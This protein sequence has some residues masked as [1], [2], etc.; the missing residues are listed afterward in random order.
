MR[1]LEL[2]S[3]AGGLAIGASR[4]GF[5]H[6]GLLELDRH[7]CETVNRN[8]RKGCE[9]VTG[10]PLTEST[11]VRGV[12]F[13]KYLDQVDLIAAGPPCQPFSM[14][15]K[16]AAHLDPRDMF[17]ETIR[18][19][20]ESRPK[21]V[22]VENVKG[23]G[24]ERYATY[25]EYILLQLT[26]PSFAPRDNE[27]MVSH[28]SRLERHNSSGGELEYRVNFQ[29]LNAADYGVPQQRQRVFIVA[30]RND[31]KADWSFQKDLP[32]TH[33]RER[34]LYNQWVT[35]SYWERHGIAPKVERPNRYTRLVERLSNRSVPPEGEAWRTVRD[36]IADLPDPE[37]SKDNGHS[38]HVFQP[39]ARAYKGHTGS[40][41]DEPA[42][43]IKAGVHG[44]PGGENM[45]RRED[46][47]VRYFTVRETARLQ[48]FPDRY[49]ISGVWSEAMRQ[50]GNAV[51]VMLGERVI[52]SVSKYLT[53]SRRSGYRTQ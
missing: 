53:P 29:C 9:T 35:G 3:G 21:V 50:L 36:A 14:G 46:G 37:R 31:V 22:V 30:F 47:T 7:C 18:A 27:D 2:F 16:H 10:W 42:K 4:A 1:S 48:C 26:Y 15:G 11:D 17:P 24:R 38:N 8:I 20:R 33:S 32:P 41:Y 6:Q 39:G 19:V 28:L 5:S 34:L 45:L 13:R 49:E 43:T 12:D 51:P 25:L 44:V 52:Q 23:L 40:P